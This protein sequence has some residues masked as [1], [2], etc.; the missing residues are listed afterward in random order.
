MRTLRARPKVKGLLR[1][2]REHEAPLTADF[3]REYGLR[4]CDV[5]RER[6]PDE[7]EDLI[8]WLPKDTA[9]RASFEAKGDHR[10]A[11]RNWGWSEQEDLLLGLI[12]LISNQTYVIAQTSSPKKLK[13]PETIP[14]P[15][16]D[17]GQ[18]P[19]PVRDADSQARAMLAAL[20]ARRKGD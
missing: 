16:Q 5:V 11:V 18:K 17:T 12:N 10:K 8:V 4:L 14:S 7:V 13:A 1:L 3:Q 6:T 19:T 20:K 9:F 15:R 2:L